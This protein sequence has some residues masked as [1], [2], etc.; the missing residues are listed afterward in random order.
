MADSPTQTAVADKP[1]GEAAIAER[2]LLIGAV[3]LITTGAFEAMAVINAMPTVVKHFGPDQ[4]FAL[5]SGIAIAMQI[6]S[7]VIAGWLADHRGVKLC[8]YLGLGFFCVGALGAG[9]APTLL[10]F[11]TARALQG[12]GGGL[13]MVP[14][15]VLIGALVAPSRRPKFFAAF[16]YAWVVPSMVGPA[17]SGWIITHF[18][19]RP[20]FIVAVPLAVLSLPLLARSVNRAPAPAPNWDDLPWRGLLAAVG[21]AGAITAWQVSGGLTSNW[22]WLLVVAAALVLGYSLH[23]LL[24]AGALTANW[25]IPAI[26]ATRLLIMAAMIGSEAFLPLVLERLHHWRPLQTGVAIALATLT[27]T[28]GSWLQ[29]RITKPQQRRR[30]PLIG[31]TLV[32]AGS[33]V[34]T[35]LPWTTIPP[36]VGLFG[37]SIVGL[38]MGLAVATTSDLALAI[39]PQSEHGQVSSSLQVADAVGPA[40]SMGLASL[41][42]SVTLGLDRP[43]RV[44]PWFDAVAFLPASVIGV[45]TAILGWLAAR[46]IYQGQET[47][48]AS[49]VLAD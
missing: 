38:G 47:T 49:D 13:V 17:V 39:A 6:V 40:L 28:A 46:R 37:W 26:I 31:T 20:V 32:V 43:A 12:I 23:H 11:A 7:T 19:W 24:P 10:V 4:W 29:A 14:L 33:V 1:T 45:V 2:E 16:S 36:F 18:S 3:I 44:G 9:L 5:V 8:L 25:G 48:R 41:A 21:C 15:Y 30:I 27:W 42:L 35:T 34:A 22:R